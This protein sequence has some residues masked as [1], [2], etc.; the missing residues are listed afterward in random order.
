M[1][2]NK[3]TSKLMVFLVIL[4]DLILMNALFTVL[5]AEWPYFKVGAIFSGAIGR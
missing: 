2:N 1:E 4:G 3:K 5:Y